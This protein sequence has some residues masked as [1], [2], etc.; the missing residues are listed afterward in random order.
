MSFEDT[1]LDVISD[2]DP[3]PVKPGGLIDRARQDE[4][5]R[6]ASA[7]DREHEDEDVS[8]RA[9]KA[10]KTADVRPE[11]GTARTVVVSNAGGIVLLLGADMLRRR[12]VI[13]TLDEP[14]MLSSSLAAASDT[15]NPVAGAGATV[16]ASGFVLPMN[17]PLV[18]E[19]RHEW[20][21]V[22]TSATPTRVCVLTESYAPET[23]R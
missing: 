2:V 10:A 14:V 20:W 21:V 23:L 1:I 8:E 17:T 3:F 11:R 18:L 4:A 19:N 15:N 7:E 22:P 5:R 12:A 13:I 9:Y 16:N 6:K